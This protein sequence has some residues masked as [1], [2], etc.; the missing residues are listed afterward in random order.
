MTPGE[1]E[2]DFIFVD[3]VVEGMVAAALASGIDGHSVDL[4]TGRAHPICHVV[5]RI[6]AETGARGRILRGEL[7]Y[8]PGEVKHLVA[9][10]DH[11]A[12]LTGWRAQVGLEEGLRAT[13]RWYKES[14][15]HNLP[16]T[17]ASGAFRPAIAES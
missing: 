13:V 7:A 6:W 8:R 10:A 11:T 9:D 5:D 16:T 3:D 17:G 4:G 1:Q 14:F 12:Q 2:R 15:E